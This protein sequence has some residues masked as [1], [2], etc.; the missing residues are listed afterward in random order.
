MAFTGFPPKVRFTPVPNPLFGPLL[1]AVAL[2]SISEFTRHLI[3]DVPGISLVLYGVLL[4][5]MV[6]FMPRGLAG[7]AL[8]RPWRRPAG[9]TVKAA[10]VGHA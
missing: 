4:V 5:V 10:E 3:G 7:L 6:M 8:R 2:H 9:A 1:G